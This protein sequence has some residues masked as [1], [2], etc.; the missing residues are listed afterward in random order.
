MS[1]PCFSWYF[2]GMWVYEILDVWL[3]I[4]IMCLSSNIFLLLFTDIV[5]LGAVLPKQMMGNSIRE[6]SDL[7]RR[8]HKNPLPSRFLDTHWSAYNQTTNGQPN[9]CYESWRYQAENEPSVSQTKCCK[10]VSATAAGKCCW[11]EG[12]RVELFQHRSVPRARLPHCVIAHTSVG[13]ASIAATAVP[14]VAL[15]GLP[16]HPADCAGLHADGCAEHGLLLLV[17]MPPWAIF[18]FDCVLT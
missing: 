14:A 3:I 18:V 13:I 7:I 11:Q 2:G 8:N 10:E 12:R 16:A 6:T 17:N 15:A 9:W 5:T 4:D 1:L